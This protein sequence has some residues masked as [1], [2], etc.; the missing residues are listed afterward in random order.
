MARLTWIGA[1][2]ATAMASA[3]AQATL[4]VPP[5]AAAVRQAD[6]YLFHSGASDVF[7]ITSSMILMGKSQTAVVRG[8][9]TMMI[10]HHTQTTSQALTIAKAAGVMPPPPELT[11]AQK[12]LIT[13][14]LAATPATIDRVYLTQQVASHQQALA[15]QQ[16]YSTRGDVPAL[17]QTAQATVPVVTSHLQSARELVR[18]AR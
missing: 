16:G 2:L 18:G 15:M 12:G 13:Q 11:A 10:D 3:S 8:Y 5:Q 17:R 7:E 4:P 9:A 1:A 6:A 14:L